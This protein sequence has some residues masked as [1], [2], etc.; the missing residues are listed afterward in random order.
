VNTYREMIA[1]ASTCHRFRHRY[2]G[3]FGFAKISQRVDK[4]ASVGAR[5][6]AST[7]PFL[8]RGADGRAG[9]LAGQVGPAVSIVNNEPVRNLDGPGRFTVSLVIREGITIMS[10]MDAVLTHAKM[11]SQPIA[12]DDS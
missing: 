12:N 7:T 4:S 9:R 6:R 10:C 8:R 3:T 11:L 1:H 5:A 2:P